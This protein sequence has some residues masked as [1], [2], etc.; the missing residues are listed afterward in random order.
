MAMEVS[1]GY[2]AYWVLAVLLAMLA[3][4]TLG[5]IG[6]L[7]VVSV[8]L[9]LWLIGLQVGRRRAAHALAEVL[10]GIAVWSPNLARIGQA[11]AV[12]HD[13]IVVDPSGMLV[14]GD[15]VLRTPDAP[16]ASGWRDTAPTSA[17]GPALR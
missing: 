11:E 17:S 2:V 10:D 13:P 3:F 12:F 7:I 6:G 14:V 8:V 9:I 4:G 1:V 15:I 5:M 16:A